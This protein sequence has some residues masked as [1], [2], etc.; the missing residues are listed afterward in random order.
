ML[1]VDRQEKIMKWLEQEEMLRISE[2]SERLNVS[3]MT[4]YRD[5]KRLIDERKIMKTS[6]GISLIKDKVSPNSCVYCMRNTSPRLVVQI[7]RKDQQVEL[8]CCAHCALLRYQDIEE[9]VSQ[10]ICK[11]FLKDTTISARNAV[12][13]MNAELDLNCCQPQFIIFDSTKQAKQFKN[14]FGGDL[15][16][17]EAAIVAVN[18]EMNRMCCHSKKKQEE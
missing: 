1:P 10:M 8:A 18:K 17:F 16:D 3:E 7:I 4:I 11:D 14:G 9:D 13:L 12:Y 15:F 2:L 6:N 5:L